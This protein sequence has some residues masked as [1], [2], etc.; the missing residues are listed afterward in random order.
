MNITSFG[1][2]NVTKVTF[3]I[4]TIIISIAIMNDK[5]KNITKIYKT[6][7]IL[8]FSNLLLSILSPEYSLLNLL[9]FDTIDKTK[10]ET[11][12]WSI[13]G[14]IG[15]ILSGHFTAL[16]FIGLLF[17]LDKQS[18]SIIQMQKSIN[19]NS[20]TMLLQNKSI[21]QQ[22]EALSLQIE[23]FKQQTIVFENQAEELSNQRKEM[24]VSKLYRQFEFYYS[25]LED[26][27]K[28]TIY[29]KKD[30]KHK[31]FNNLISDM[32]SHENCFI[33]ENDLS[34]ILDYYNF[35]HTEIKNIQYKD[36]KNDLNKYFNLYKKP[37]DE[38]HIKQLKFKIK[39]MKELGGYELSQS[40]NTT[41]GSAFE[42]SH[43][44]LLNKV[45]F[46]E[47]DDFEKYFSQIENQNKQRKIYQL[48]EGLII[49]PIFERY[50]IT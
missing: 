43:K 19:Q 42:A 9:S 38:Y 22:S 40:F 46:I 23:E 10:L 13:R 41:R 39:I 7:A 45:K 8:I 49:S 29:Y 21:K 50:I 3:I 18:K 11:D 5:N 35:I 16:A 4:L 32:K 12:L 28:N 48:L 6:I 24:E 31:N 37:I 33:N 36:I 25:Q 20:N 44:G 26:L 34:I 30:E 47:K 14:Q 17:S 27:K 1:I 2:E 15:D